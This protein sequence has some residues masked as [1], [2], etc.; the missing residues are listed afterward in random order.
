MD[1]NPKPHLR[2]E[3]SSSGKGGEEEVNLGSCAIKVN[4]DS[5]RTFSLQLPEESSFLEVSRKGPLDILG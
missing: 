1:G 4:L 3:V 5:S 2:L